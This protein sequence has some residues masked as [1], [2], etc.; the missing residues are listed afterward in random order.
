MELLADSHRPQRTDARPSRGESRHRPEAY[1]AHAGGDA[2]TITAVQDVEVPL[3]GLAHASLRMPMA[4]TRAAT[5]LATATPLVLP[6]PTVSPRARSEWTSRAVNFTVALVALVLLAP[7][8]LVVALLVRLTSPGPILYTQVRVGQDRR[9]LRGRS[10]DERR[11]TDHGGRLFTI[12]KF[13]SMRVDAEADGQA[14]WARANDDRVTPIGRMLRRTRLDELP[15]L[16][17]VLMGDMNIV[18]PRPERPVIFAKL[19]ADIA[20]YPLRQLAKPGITGWAQ[21]NHTYDTCVDDVRIKVRYDLEYLQ[22][23]SVV[24]DLKIMAMT[25]PVMIFRKSG[26]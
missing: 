17:N 11:R 21:V 26:W 10:S 20:E 24:E 1:P 19:R 7:V 14:V 8:L 18:G 3:D 13:R 2:A 23:Q 4:D 22:R 5:S 12:Y 6:L 15:Q 25:V 16:W 9:G